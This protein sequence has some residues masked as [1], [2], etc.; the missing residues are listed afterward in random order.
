[1]SEIFA[2]ARE[3]KRF[4]ATRQDDRLGNKLF[5]ADEAHIATGSV[6]IATISQIM[7]V[8]TTETISPF[9]KT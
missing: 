9:Q 4:A 6:F 3:T 1:V 7:I 2:Q 5:V 8:V